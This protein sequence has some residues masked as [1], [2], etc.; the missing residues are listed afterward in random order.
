[1]ILSYRRGSL[2]VV[3]AGACGTVLLAELSF[4]GHIEGDIFMRG[5]RRQA[6]ISVLRDAAGRTV[7]KMVTAAVFLC[8]KKETENINVYIQM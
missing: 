2:I 6:D 8:L 1:M 5:N 7:C 4:N 3:A